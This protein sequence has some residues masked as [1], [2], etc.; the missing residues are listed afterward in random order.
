LIYWGLSII[1]NLASMMAGV[2]INSGSPAAVG[3]LVLV[4]GLNALFLT[5]ISGSVYVELLR[6]KG[7]GV[8]AAATAEIFA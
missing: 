5:S 4:T 1:I 8:G 7:G 3:V 6:I 2:L